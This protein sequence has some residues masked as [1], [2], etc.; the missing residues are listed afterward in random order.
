MRWIIISN[1]IHIALLGNCTTNYISNALKEICSQYGILAEIYNAPFNQY[2]QEALSPNS[3]L[4]LSDPELIILFLEGKYLFPD[5]FDMKAILSDKEHKLQLIQDTF[6]SIESLVDSIHSTRNVKIIINNFHVPYHTPLG[7]LDNKNCLGLKRML[8]TLNLKLEEWAISKDYLHIFDY[9]GFCSHVGRRSIEDEKLSYSTKSPISISSTK[10]IVKEY[11]RFI[12]PLKSK[13]KK[14][15]VLDLDN[16]LWG[17][18]AGEDGIAGIKL[19][20]D[21]PSKTFYD[22]QQEI[23]NLYHRGILLAVNSKN[24]F[25]DAIE[26][27]ENHPHMLLRKSCFSSLKINWKDKVTNLREIA[28]ELNI[29]IDSLVFFDDN[30]VEREYVKLALPEVT[31]VEVPKDSC[32][33]VQVLK[34]IVEFE[35]LNITSE[36]TKRNRMVEENK[37][38]LELFSKLNDLEDYLTS[39]QTKVIV[40]FANEFNIPRLAQLTQKTNQFNMTTS[41]YQSEEIENMIKTGNFLVFFCSVSDRFGDSGTIGVCIVRLDSAAAFI[42]TFLLS[43]RVLGRNVEYAFLNAVT[44]ILKKKG[45]QKISSKYIQTAKSKAN[46]DFYRNAGFDQHCTSDQETEFLLTEFKNLRNINYIDTSIIV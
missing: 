22:F 12:L 15:L 30:P 45:I 11:M 9:N 46:Q 20:I 5:W 39:L 28:K 16:T 43:C 14:C 35:Q 38:R 6:D 26:I 24:N 7:I 36:D 19:D 8:N 33:Y 25:E 18:I 42:D 17:G 1:Q 40:E 2:T 3:G 4:N 27:I 37:K 31:V 41:R 32:R 13:N 10:E 29:G 34:A 23:L 44:E 21:G